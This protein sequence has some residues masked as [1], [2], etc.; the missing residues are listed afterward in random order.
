M[1]IEKIVNG[2]DTLSDKQLSDIY[3]GSDMMANTNDAI[4]TCSCRGT[5]DNVNNGLWCSCKGNPDL[6]DPDPDPDQK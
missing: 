1:K 6:S 5:G 3:G 2:G 4:I